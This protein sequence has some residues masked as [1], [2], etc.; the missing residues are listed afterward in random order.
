MSDSEIEHVVTKVLERVKPANRPL[1]SLQLIISIVLGACTIF[2][3]LKSLAIIPDRVDAQ[4]KALR[5]RREYD[6]QQDARITLVERS[7]FQTDFKLGQM[8]EQL[9]KAV[10]TLDQI[11]RKTP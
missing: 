1:V 11:N 9:G 4:E 7:T 2:V 10:V 3:A 8:Q 6:V 5:E